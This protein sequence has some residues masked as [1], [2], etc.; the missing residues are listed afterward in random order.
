MT[1][2]LSAFKDAYASVTVAQYEPLILRWVSMWTLGTL[3]DVSVLRAP[4]AARMSQVDERLP[5]A[6]AMRAARMGVKPPSVEEVSVPPSR[7]TPGDAVDVEGNPIAAGAVQSV[8]AA[9]LPDAVAVA[10]SLFPDGVVRLVEAGKE[11]LRESAPAR[12]GF[13]F[14]RA[15]GSLFG[16]GGGG[17]SSDVGLGVKTVPTSLN[18]SMGTLPA[19]FDFHAERTALF[20]KLNAAASRWADDPK[21]SSL[22]S[23]LHRAGA[24]HAYQLLPFH[25]EEALSPIGIAHFYRQL[26]FNLEEGFGPVEEAFTIAPLETLEVVYETVRRQIHEEQIEFGSEEISETA[27]EVKNLDEV[28]DKVSSM[29]QHDTSAGMS[30]GASG[31][32]AGIWQASASANA[33]MSVSTQRGREDTSRRLKEVTSRASERITKSFALKIRDTTDVTTTNMTRRVIRNEDSEPVSYGLRRVLRKVRVKVQ[34]LGPQ[35]VWQLYVRE[36]G[37]GLARSRFVH[38]RDPSEI[39]VPDMPPGSPPRPKGGVDTGT[40]SAALAWDAA[41]VTY[42]VTVVVTPGPGRKVTRVSIDSISDLDGGG[43][44]DEAPSPANDNQWDGKLDLATNS[45]S[46]KVAIRPGSSPS[47][48]IAYTYAWDPTG[49]VMNEWEEQMKA[50]KAAMEEKMLQEK[51]E[52]DKATLTELSKVRPRPANDL[53]R[54]ER[55]EVMNRM[56]SQL[57]ARGDDPSEPTPLEIEFFHRFFDI[58]KMFVYTHP[59][60]WKPRYAKVA[61]GFGRPEYAITAESEPAALGS[62]LGWLIQ[63]DGDARRD[64]FL[65]SPWLRACLPIKPGREREAIEW[66][67]KHIEG[68]TGYDTE[69][70]VLADLLEEIEAQRKREGELGQVGA[71]YVAIETKPGVPEGG[72]RPENVY[73]VIEEFDVTLPTEGFV[74]DRLDLG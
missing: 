14:R 18:R 37:A 68:E 28:S 6:L 51:F 32:A 10:G 5:T 2:K 11:R 54:E 53:R 38:F 46:V 65:N 55:Y 21:T 29:I 70:G 15:L 7:Q 23:L 47:V 26:Y 59:S 71:D 52:H 1:T 30:V 44:E 40:T 36:P 17:A 56:V 12:G 27:T 3:A 24:D 66:L 50:A 63:I 62:S 73:P 25:I 35:L 67:A 61:S 45:Y 57:F 31:G 20:Q 41:R 58:E 19:D 49:E 60:W 4:K 34:D 33:S 42:Y 64:E 39:A 13:M 43:K 72:V 9:G 74:Y 16:L 8:E 48:N 22:S 69:H